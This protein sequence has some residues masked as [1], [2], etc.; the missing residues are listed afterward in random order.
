MQEGGGELLELQL[1][2]D[3]HRPQDVLQLFV[4]LNQVL[5]V[6]LLCQQLP[7]AL[8][9]CLPHSL[10]HPSDQVEHHEYYFQPGLDQPVLVVPA[11]E[12]R[13]AGRVY[14]VIE[15]NCLQ[16]AQDG[17]DQSAP[18]L[19][20]DVQVFDV[21]PVLFV[22]N[23]GVGVYAEGLVVCGLG[24][25]GGDLPLLPRAVGVARGRGRRIGR[26]SGL[27]RLSCLRGLLL[28]HDYLGEVFVYFL[29]DADD[30]LSN[31]DNFLESLVEA[32]GLVALLGN[33]EHLEGLVYF[34]AVLKGNEQLKG[35]E[36]V[37]EH[38]E[39]GGVAFEG[40]LVD[41]VGDPEEVLD[42]GDDGDD[43][44]FEVPPHCEVVEGVLGLGPRRALF[45]SVGHCLP[46]GT[47]VEQLVESYARLLHHHVNKLHRYFVALE[48]VADQTVQDAVEDSFAPF[49]PEPFHEHFFAFQHV[50]EHFPGDGAG[51]LQDFE[52]EDV[53]D[54]GDSHKD[55]FEEVGVELV[56]SAGRGLVDELAQD[57]E[58]CILEGKDVV[59]VV[60]VGVE[61]DL[62]DIFQ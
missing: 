51:V 52:G 46:A 11:A 17:P 15:Q 45:A 35:G 30:L 2:A 34:A 41:V 12:H 29:V 10:V 21:E 36:A 9:G 6:L 43:F 50:L 18:V 55:S 4:I 54:G 47:P 40:L 14:V 60:L 61:P 20:L 1:Q 16:E 24:L 39:E 26:P 27:V 3:Q 58:G 53:G 7:E 31:G 49:C 57:S 32:D 5:G 37:V 19:H 25:V 62:V 56:D 23:E 8:V 33:G 48:G 28:L 13:L 59:V 44:Q 22:V 38:F 42:E